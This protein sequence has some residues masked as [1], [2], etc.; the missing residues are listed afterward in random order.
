MAN[1][2]LHLLRH[3]EAVDDGVLSERGQRQARL[4]GRRL[5]GLPITAIHHSPLVRAVQTTQLVSEFLPGVPVHASELVGDY[6]PPVPDPTVL[7][8]VY[9]R[10][11]DGM[12]AQEYAVGAELAT[13]AIER[14]A[15]PAEIDT[16]ELI[17]THNFLIGWFVRHALDAPA[18]RWLGL[19]QG[20]CALTTILYR[21][22]R[23]PAVVLFNDMGHLSPDLRWT[24][25][26][27]K[28]HI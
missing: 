4:A 9:T 7:P 19:N 15:V 8:E 11:L 23:P 27:A 5:A 12:T 14:H 22:D 6:L 18:W 17:V 24:G 1:R 21:P 3:G 2:F 16:H 25:F 13:A 20:N 28:Q 26:P 10:F